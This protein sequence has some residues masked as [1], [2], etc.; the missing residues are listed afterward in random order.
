MATW[1]SVRVMYD[2]KD[3]QGKEVKAKEVYLIDA[4]SFTEA[5]ARAI[6]EVTPFVE[7]AGELKVTAM[8][9]EDIV[10]IFN[11]EDEDADRWYRVKVVF[12]TMD[13]KTMKEKKKAQMCLVKGKSTEDATKRLH[14]GM[15]GSLADYVIHTVSETQ[16]EDVFFYNFDKVT[17]ETR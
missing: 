3:E 17:D 12:V 10:E 16:Y 14:D 7:K 6:G 15:R 2:K 13:E 4:L 5:E 1:F 8:K 11:T 9:M